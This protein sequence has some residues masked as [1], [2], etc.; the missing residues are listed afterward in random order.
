MDEGTIADYMDD[1]YHNVTATIWT[2][3]LLLMNKTIDKECKED[4]A[5]NKMFAIDLSI[6]GR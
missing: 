2:C 4:H 6:E 1:K 5:F 3:Q